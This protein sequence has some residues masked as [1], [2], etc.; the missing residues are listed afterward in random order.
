M[1]DRPPPPIT[2]EHKEA[3]LHSGLGPSMAS[4]PAVGHS[5]AADTD[6]GVLSDS[7]DGPEYLAAPPGMIPG[8]DWADALLVG[9]TAAGSSQVRSTP[10][11]CCG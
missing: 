3:A 11:R 4:M 8:T 9:G 1:L 7:S 2:H 10:I 5:P 6:D